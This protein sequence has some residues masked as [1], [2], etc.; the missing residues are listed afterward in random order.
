MLYLA[1]LFITR[2]VGVLVMLVLVL[3]MLDLLG[4]SGDILGLSLIHI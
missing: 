1:R 2:I 3:M 4:E